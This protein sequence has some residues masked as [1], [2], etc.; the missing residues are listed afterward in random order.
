VRLIEARDRVRARLLELRA[1]DGLWRGR[2]SSSALATAVAL[3]AL[4]RV[5]GHDELVRKGV[6]WLA[7][8]QLPDGGFG[9]TPGSVPNL[10][11]TVLCWA[12]LKAAG[13][14][15][16]APVVERARAWIDR[17]AGEKPLAHAVSD[18]Y[19]EDRTFS[20]PIL[21]FCASAGVL[22]WHDVPQLPFELAAL[23]RRLYNR[24]GM[25]V[26]SY[27][28]PALIA[29]GLVRYRKDAGTNPITRWMR[30][31]AS[32]PVLEKLATLQPSGGGFLEATPLTAFVT[33]ALVE[34]GERRHAVVA[35]GARFLAASARADGSWPIDTDL[36]VWLTTLSI[37]ALGGEVPDRDAL[38]DRLIALQYRDEHPYT[39]AAPGGWAW[40]DQ[41]GGV[42]DAD[43]TAG[44]VLALA[45]LGVE[46][47]G[48]REAAERGLTWLADLQNADGG[49]PTFCRG[50]GHLPFDRSAPDLT[51]HAL[52][53]V[54]AW[55]GRVAPEL[56]ARLA[57]VEKK[58]LAYLER[59]QRPDG[60]WLPLWFGNQ[61][62]PAMENP[63]YGTARV[64]R[65]LG[66]GAMK[67]RAIAWLKSARGADG[68]GGAPGV[69]ASVEETAVAVEALADDSTSVE[70]L[71]RIVEQ[72]RFETAAPIG[73]YFAKLWYDEALYPVIFTAAAA[74]RLTP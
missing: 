59:T 57:R 56:A 21:A 46:H 12:A 67:E 68:W 24:V 33:L 58:A 62:A 41:P 69:A 38:R 42:P 43:D 71:T 20:A 44:A 17:A 5:R 18:A 2:L 32:A 60:A 9:D 4:D 19:G 63:V 50:W 8:T 47:A 55:R 30:R 66:E 70:L 74:S 49:M 31:I 64:I 37:N 52:R 45:T 14:A 61:A 48:A 28:L 6:S 23:P 40:T 13:G 53:A 54:A 36:A 10:S 22:P 1:P 16:A 27:A 29:I 51:A 15:E 34:A 65:A 11:T 73:L 26:V 7:M 35:E 72:G 3:L 39:G 25:Q